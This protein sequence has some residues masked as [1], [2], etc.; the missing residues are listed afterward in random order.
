[1]GEV[2]KWVGP[3]WV[4]SWARGLLPKETP[5]GWFLGN[6][7]PQED[8]GKK[9]GPG[10]VEGWEGMKGKRKMEDGKRRKKEKE[11]KEKEEN[12]ERQVQKKT[13][14][15]AAPDKSLRPPASGALASG[16]ACLGPCLRPGSTSGSDTQRGF[17]R[18]IVSD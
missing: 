8:F 14:V 18:A 10:R 17:F 9:E 15:S 13:Q 3:R 2:W 7:G 6:R 4:S 5:E 16:P 11:E 12:K 1:M